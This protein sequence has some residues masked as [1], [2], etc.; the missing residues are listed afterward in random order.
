MPQFR[1]R[2]AGAIVRFGHQR[3]FSSDLVLLPAANLNLLILTS[4]RSEIS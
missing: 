1:V 4:Y 3:V 2:G